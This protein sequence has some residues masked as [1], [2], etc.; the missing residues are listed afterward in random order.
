MI[1]AYKELIPAQRKVQ[2]KRKPFS[3][4]KDS[5]LF[6][7][8]MLCREEPRSLSSVAGFALALR[9]SRTNQ[10]LLAG[11]RCDKTASLLSP[12]TQTRVQAHGFSHSFAARQNG[13]AKLINASQRL[14]RRDEESRTL[15]LSRMPTKSVVLHLQETQFSLPDPRGQHK[16][17]TMIDWWYSERSNGKS[18]NRSI[19]GRG[20]EGN[21][22]II[23]RTVLDPLRMVPESARR[24]GR[25]EDVRTVLDLCH[26]AKAK[27]A[28]RV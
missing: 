15:K 1:A 3:S 18:R 13:V 25:I 17:R 21:A 10:V 20:G 27:Q 24:P 6:L 22:T 28:F 23:R 26:R 8:D 5:A 2:G 19:V 7:K 9:L 14:A 12:L 11:R 16:N 4:S